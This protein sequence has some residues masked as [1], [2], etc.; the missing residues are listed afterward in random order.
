MKGAG[1]VRKAFSAFALSSCGL[2][3]KDI[4]HYLGRQ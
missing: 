1:I 3:S 2:Y 4:D